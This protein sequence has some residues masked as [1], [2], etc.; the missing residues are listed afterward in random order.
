[1]PNIAEKTLKDFIEE[2]LSVREFEALPDTLEITQN[3]LTMILKNPLIMDMSELF[4]MAK[5]LG[6]TWRKLIEEFIE[7]IK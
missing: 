1:M 7:P 6:I 3:K 5:V 2:K 4:A